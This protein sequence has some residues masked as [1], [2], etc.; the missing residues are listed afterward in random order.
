MDAKESLRR[1]LRVDSL[2]VTAA[3]LVH[4][5]AG[6][7]AAAVMAREGE[8]DWVLYGLMGLLTAVVLT[9]YGRLG[10]RAT[11]V[12]R[13]VSGL[14]SIAVVAAWGALL[15]DRITP[16][17]DAS[18]MLGVGID[19]PWLLLAVGL[20]AIVVGLVG[21]HIVA[22]APKTRQQ[23]KARQAEARAALQQAKIAREQALAQTGGA[24][25]DAP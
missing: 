4:L 9:N 10:A 20:E 5:L 18:G 7:V 15:A 1:V 2:V 19:R 3:V 17:T 23:A 14:F 11:L 25:E 16:S 13:V 22:L 12:R 8:P 24:G 6:A 21:F